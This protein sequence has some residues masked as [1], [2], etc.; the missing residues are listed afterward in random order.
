MT[1]GRQGGKAMGQARARIHHGDNTPVLDRNFP[2]PGI[3]DVGVG[4]FAYASNSAP[5][6]CIWG[7]VVGPNIQLASSPDLRAWTLL[8]RDALPV[9]PA[10]ATRGATW[11]PHAV[12]IDGS[13]RLYFAA[14][15][16]GHGDLA[17]GVATADNPLGPFAPLTAPLVDAPDA[18]GVIDPFVFTEDDGARWLIW[19]TDGNSRGLP[20]WIYA[21]RLSLDGLALLGSPFPLIRNDQGWEGAVVEAPTLWKAG[22]R[23]HLL[24]SANACTDERYGIGHAVA[25]SLLGPYVKATAPLFRSGPERI[26]PGGQDL[27]AVGGRTLML[28]HGWDAALHIRRLYLDEISFDAPAVRPVAG[29]SHARAMPRA[30][31]VTAS[32]R[33]IHAA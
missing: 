6:D 22:G 27:V 26:G 21:Q 33:A 24:Y 2:D 16:G 20:T 9:L 30:G 8:D 5:G 4:Y 7:A 23:Y 10:W 25:P 29:A 13:Y 14:R 19:K 28:S 1:N 15:H 11:A 18:G 32:R 3:L 12:G 31:R 17:I